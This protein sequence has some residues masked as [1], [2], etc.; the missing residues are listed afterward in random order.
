MKE[1]TVKELEKRVEQLEDIIS[2][3][4][5]G[6]DYVQKAQRV[7]RDVNIGLMLGTV[8][9]AGIAAWILLRSGEE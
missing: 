8:A 3:K 5:I 9:A 1:R 6:A 7:Q 2:Q 4:G